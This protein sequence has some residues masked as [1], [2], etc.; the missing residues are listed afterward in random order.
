MGKCAALN[1]QKLQNP[2]LCPGENFSALSPIWTL[3]FSGHICA[4]LAANNKMN[5]QIYQRGRVFFVGI[6]Q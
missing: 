2:H 6:G 4:R 3:P 5:K 1:H